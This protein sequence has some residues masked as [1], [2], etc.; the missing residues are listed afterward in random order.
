[1]KAPGTPGTKRLKLEYDEPPSHFAC[2]F[3]L[4]LYTT[5]NIVSYLRFEEGPCDANVDKV[6][7]CW[8]TLSNPS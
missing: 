3:N 7:R 5:A 8:L 1:L 4:R 2:N 6:G